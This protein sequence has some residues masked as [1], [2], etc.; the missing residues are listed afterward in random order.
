MQTFLHI[1]RQNQ[2]FSLQ[3][4]HFYM[5]LQNLPFE[6]RFLFISKVLYEFTRKKENSPEGNKKGDF[7]AAWLMCRYK[8]NHME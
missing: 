2:A 6:K 5:C 4:I 7:Y 3:N 1:K 8:E